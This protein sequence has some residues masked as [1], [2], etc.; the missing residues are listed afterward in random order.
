MKS[1]T[2]VAE[3]AH[4]LLLRHFLLSHHSWE[5]ASRLSSQHLSD[6]D[7]LPQQVTLLH[8]VKVSPLSSV[9]K[10]L[11]REMAASGIIRQ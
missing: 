3:V 1:T 8:P 10:L 4:L 9:Q 7:S 11:Q 5:A 2:N 6:V